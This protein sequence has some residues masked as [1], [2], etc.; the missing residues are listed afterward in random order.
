MTVN[1]ATNE[2]LT[3]DDVGLAAAY[4][5]SQRQTEGPFDIAVNLEFPPDRSPAA[6]LCRAFEAAGATWC[7][8]LSPD[9][10]EEYR[11]QIR[12]GPRR[13]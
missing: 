5:K 2:L 8:A 12:Q 13:I 1:Q 7:V 10:V 11:E 3:P 6:D 9:T 4:V